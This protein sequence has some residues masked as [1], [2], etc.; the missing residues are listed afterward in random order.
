[1]GSYYNDRTG[2]ATEARQTKPGQLSR[3]PATHADL[4]PQ[5]NPPHPVHHPPQ[6]QPQPNRTPSIINQ[7]THP[8][9]HAQ[10]LKQP[11]HRPPLLT[12]RPHPPRHS[13]PQRKPARPAVPTFDARQIG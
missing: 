4:P 5:V 12:P 2:S 7:P 3:P 8:P 1:M 6:P 11:T 9:P 13:Q 10:P